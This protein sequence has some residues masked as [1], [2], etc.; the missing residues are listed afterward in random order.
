MPAKRTFLTPPKLNYFYKQ[1]QHVLNEKSCLVYYNPAR[2]L[3][4]NI[5]LNKKTGMNGMIYQIK[6]TLH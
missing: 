2:R 6:K 3:L 5:N 1:L 4:A